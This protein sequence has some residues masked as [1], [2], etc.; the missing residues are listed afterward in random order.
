MTQGLQALAKCPPKY[1]REY[2]KA[3]MKHPLDMY[4]TDFASTNGTSTKCV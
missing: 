2:L 4:D 1:V 3:L